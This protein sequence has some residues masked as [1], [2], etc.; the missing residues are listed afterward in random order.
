MAF[1]S[2]N[3]P[4]E[5]RIALIVHFMA[6][7]V[8]H[9]STKPGEHCVGDM[10]NQ[11]EHRLAERLAHTDVQHNVPDDADEAG[12]ATELRIRHRLCEHRVE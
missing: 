9:R 4:C 8:L 3:S 10:V 12:Y 5:Y 1:A 6:E 11:A 7:R 2:R